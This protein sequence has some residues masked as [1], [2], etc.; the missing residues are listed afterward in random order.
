M[1]ATVDPGEVCCDLT[2]G[3][4]A[5]WA[6]D[7]RGSVMRIDPRDGRIVDRL[8][9]AIDPT[10]HTNAV[11]AGGSLWVSS[12]STALFR[13]DPGSGSTREVDTGGGVPFVADGGLVW[14]AA[15][16]VLW[17]VDAETGEVVERIPLQDSIEVISLGIGFGAIWAGIRHV[18]YVGAVLRIDPAT[19][20]VLDEV[21]D[22]EIPARIAFG[23]GSV[24]V[25][26]SGSSSLYRISPGV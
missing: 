14:G 6:V 24:W 11:Y 16:D 4:G 10:V 1:L 3:E 9:V 13:V 2:A 26:D 19:G 15:P 20:E 5:V 22:V 21:S 8:E 25:T 17:A 12:D 18:G 23:F 7:P